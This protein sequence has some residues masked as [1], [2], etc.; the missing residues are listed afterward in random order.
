MATLSNWLF[1]QSLDSKNIFEVTQELHQTAKEL[2]E[3]KSQ[4]DKFYKAVY[5][6]DERIQDLIRERHSLTEEN[7]KLHAENDKLHT[8]NDKLHAEND[9]LRE[10]IAKLREKIA[11]LRVNRCDLTTTQ[12]FRPFYFKSKKCAKPSENGEGTF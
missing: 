6:K 7:D 10:E 3:A 11:E 5:V 4:I 2:S 8:E 12:L 9:E 1:T